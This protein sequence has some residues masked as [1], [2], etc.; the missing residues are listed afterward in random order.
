MQEVTADQ[1]TRMCVAMS[2]GTGGRHYWMAA[3]VDWAEL[4]RRGW[5]YTP[6]SGGWL[7]YDRGPHRIKARPDGHLTW[8][9]MLV[10]RPP[11][12]REQ[13]AP[14]PLKAS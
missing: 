1:I 13:S 6:T 7:V 9:V 4:V 8:G 11:G 5:E 3:Q 12:P 2:E 10:R 14:Q